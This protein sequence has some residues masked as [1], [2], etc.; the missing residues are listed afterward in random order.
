MP[1]IRVG[2]IG[3]S[4]NS[5]TGWAAKAHL[6][7]LL[8]SSRYQITAICNTS[9]DSAQRA[10]EHF[11]LPKSTNAYGSAEEMAKDPD[12]HLAVCVTGVEHHY[13]MLMPL[14]EAGKNVYTEVPLAVNITEVRELQALAE[15]KNVRTMIGLQGQSNPAVEAIRR[16]IG[17]GK[18]GRVLSTTITGYA[19]AFNGDP[20]PKTS[21]HLFRR[22]AGANMMTV[23]FLHSRTPLQA[24]P[25]CHRADLFL[26]VQLRLGRLRRARLFRFDARNLASQHRYLRC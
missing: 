19:G 7:Y 17:E 22:V 10:I 12:V 25:T 16:T 20:R 21:I 6:P 4:T 9:I 18:I 14:L 13:R 8:A 24:R 23:W 15:R 11:K 3:L 26:S 1:A 5:D 2:L